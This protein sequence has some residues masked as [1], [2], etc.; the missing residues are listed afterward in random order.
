MEASVIVLN[1]TLK[2]DLNKPI[3][4]S[5]EVKKGEG[6]SIAFHAPNVNI[7]PIRS[8][9]FVGNVAEGGPVNTNIVSF[10]PHGNSTHTE[11][12]AHI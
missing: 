9:S 12:L 2:A 8:G 10:N 5:V 1:K 7:E 6:S 3:D 11:S 4:L